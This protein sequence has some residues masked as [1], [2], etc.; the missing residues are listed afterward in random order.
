MTDGPSPTGMF[1]D[2]PEPDAIAVAL[3]RFQQRPAFS[4]GHCHANALRFGEA[5]FDLAFRSFVNTQMARHRERLRA[6]TP[7]SLAA[8]A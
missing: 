4:A 6:G 7:L 1:F 3:R 2:V 5:Q 8:A